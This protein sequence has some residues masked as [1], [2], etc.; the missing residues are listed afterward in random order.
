MS[1]PTAF[2]VKSA[3]RVF[4]ILELLI[5]YPDG[6]TT[7]EIGKR[8]GIAGS[9]IHALIKTMAAR[10]YVRETSS[11]HIVLGT[12]FYEFAQSFAREPLLLQCKPAMNRLADMFNENVHVAVL[13]G[14]YAVFIAVHETTHPIRYHNKVGSAQ[15][16]HATAVGKM[17]LS[18][19]SDE[20]IRKMYDGFAFVPLTGHTITSV[21]QLVEQ[22][23]CIRERGYSVDNGESYEGS[24]CYAA[25]IYS[26]KELAAGISISI[27]HFRMEVHREQAMIDAV[28]EAGRQISR[29]LQNHRTD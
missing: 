12:K 5:Q 20:T 17:L 9:S 3:D 21:G 22:L 16:A 1:A 27:P 18:R 14:K 13:D 29:Q 2:S 7:H 11:R 8:L 26:G 23:R 19:C 28:V 24:R 15:H 6:M 4:D 10:R 25:P